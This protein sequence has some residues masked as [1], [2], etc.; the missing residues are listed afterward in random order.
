[1][2]NTRFVVD[3]SNIAT[4][5]RSLPSLAQLESALAELKRE[6]PK[7]EVTV[8]VDATFAHRIDPSE[9]A[10]FEKALTTGTYIIPPAGAIG[11]GDALVLR[12]AEK[13]NA[14]VLSNDSFQ[15]FH[16]EHA[17]LFD[18]DRLL[19]ASP[20]PG[21]GWIFI[22]RNPVRGVKSRAA[23]R[24]V[25]N[26]PPMPKPKTPPPSRAKKAVEV[27]QTVEEEPMEESRALSRS[28]S[29]H[30]VATSVAAV[31]DP[32]TF[33]TF[34]ASH[35]VG[36][37]IDAEV[38]S[39]TS[40][41]AIIRFQGVHCYAPLAGLG[42][43]PPRSP[44]EVLKRGEVR[45]FVVRGLDPQRRGVELALPGGV[46][47]TEMTEPTELAPKV[48]KKAPAKKSAAA[49]RPTKLT[50]PKDDLVPQPTVADDVNGAPAGLQLSTKKVTTKRAP[51]KKAPP[52]KQSAKKRMAEKRALKRAVPP[53]VAPV[54][55]GQNGVAASTS[56]AKKTAVKL[57]PEIS[58]TMKPKTPK[59]VAAKK[60]V[61]QTAVV[62][63]PP[64]KRRASTKSSPI[65]TTAQQKPAK[66]RSTATQPTKR[67]TPDA[68]G[69]KH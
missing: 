57:S 54:S 42:S 7:A 6:H 17:W 62:K 23:V 67:G 63:A 45:S 3:G 21:V 35:P 25:R 61:P 22:P 18:A 43:P 64:A 50:A 15:E 27:P 13:A 55:D 10:H 41:G 69:Q 53:R 49:K 2:P 34:I 58:P 19:G 12:I 31:N 14:V 36:E 59:K 46:E 20:V 11:R 68:R 56:T 32:T 65:K 51:T 38:E 39:F 40:H 1:M 66:K 5:G 29:S 30:K 26:L 47:V 24:G 33:I 52:T 60:N 44:R 8:V 4:E 16:G 9:L 37:L 28:R 48:A